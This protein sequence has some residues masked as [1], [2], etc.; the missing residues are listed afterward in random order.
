MTQRLNSF[1]VV[2]RMV[3]LMT[4]LLLMVNIKRQNG[5]LHHFD[6]MFTLITT[7]K[8]IVTGL[9]GI[10]QIAKRANFIRNGWKLFFPDAM[11]KE[12]SNCTNIYLYKK[13][14]NK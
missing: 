4:A 6:L 8:H 12:I 3:K 5:E 2:K 10:K 7:K 1:L 13:Q 14:I 9:P 11:I